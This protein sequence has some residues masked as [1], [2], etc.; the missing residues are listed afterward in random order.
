[1]F[2]LLDP[3]PGSLGLRFDDLVLTA[4]FAVAHFTAVAA[5]AACPCCGSPSDRVHSHYR[6]T[7]ADLPCQERRLALRL[8]LRRFRCTKTDCPRVVFCERLPGLLAAH[9]RS[10][11]RLTDSQR[12][13]GF[14]LGG[15]AGARFAGRLDLPA[16]PDTLLRRVK[17]TAD[18]PAPAPRYVGVDDWAIRKGQRYGT[19]LIDLERG[20][21]LD[22]LPGRD[23]AALTA[24]LKSHPRRRV[25]HPRPLGGVRASGGR[26][27]RHKPGRWRI[28]GIC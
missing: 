16:S 3:L 20:R 24:W 14:A 15:E 27:G 7:V 5:S 22:L 23:G 19:I 28:A 2:L 8:R 17:E 26:G 10:T 25:D 13:V 6:R 11:D 1:M 4:D 12:A 9:A 18:E 21:V